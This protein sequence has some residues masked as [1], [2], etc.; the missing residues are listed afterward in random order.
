MHNAE[1]LGEFYRGLGTVVRIPK[2]VTKSLKK[3]K[4]GAM[5][6]GRNK[7]EAIPKEE[8]TGTKAKCAALSW[9]D[10]HKAKFS[11]S[12]A[13]HTDRSEGAGG[14]NPHWAAHGVNY[15]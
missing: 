4:S 6:L 1:I 7:G 3:R 13:G 9:L 15:W 12:R 2:Y 10:I 5:W 14:T 11:M 8:N